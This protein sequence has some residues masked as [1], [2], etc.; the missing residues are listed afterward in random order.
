METHRVFPL[1][2]DFIKQAP[3]INWMG[4]TET[5]VLAISNNKKLIPACLSTLVSVLTKQKIQSD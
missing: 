1:E 5:P 4:E 3:L 2:V